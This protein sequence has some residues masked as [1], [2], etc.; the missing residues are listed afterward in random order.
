[1]SSVVFGW[2]FVVHLSDVLL[3][4]MV[5]ECIDERAKGIKV[6]ATRAQ[7]N[8]PLPSQVGRHQLFRSVT[9]QLSSAETGT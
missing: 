3:M 8:C 9:G 5:I 2:H 4:K 6:H 7:D 1:M